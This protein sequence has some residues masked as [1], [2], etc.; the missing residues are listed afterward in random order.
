MNW[1][2]EDGGPEPVGF[3]SA[4]LH[5]DEYYAMDAHGQVWKQDETV[6]LDDVDKYYSM[7]ITTA[8]LQAAQ[9]SG[10]QRI[11]RA[12]ALCEKVGVM[13][14]TMTVENDFLQNDPQVVTWADPDLSSFPNTP[15]MQPMIHVRRQ[16]CQAVRITIEDIPDPSGLAS[17]GQGF[18]IAG[19]TLEVGL[20]RGMVKVAKA[21]RS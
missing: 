20:K 14:L 9:Q 6:W 1:D 8:W 21:Q 7:K 5:N 10:W 17:A 11:Y 18:T 12:T 3:G 19:F 15:V 2:V 16:K 13:G 4:C